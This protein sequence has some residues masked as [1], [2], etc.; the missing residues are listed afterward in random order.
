M[1]LGSQC[2]TL[3][4]FRTYEKAC[5]NLLNFFQDTSR[6]ES[7]AE[8][9]AAI[10]KAADSAVPVQGYY[11]EHTKFLTSSFL[12]GQRIVNAERHVHLKVLPSR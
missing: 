10:I 2:G 9:A 6:V 1:I 12:S 8:N 3:P 4:S 7:S 5:P 11:S